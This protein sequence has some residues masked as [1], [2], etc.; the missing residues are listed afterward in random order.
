MLPEAFCWPGLREP[1]EPVVLV[2]AAEKK[3]NAG[4]K[5]IDAT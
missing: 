4:R 3:N 1:I 5:P 2:P